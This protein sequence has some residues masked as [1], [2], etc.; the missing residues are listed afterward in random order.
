MINPRWAEVVAIRAEIG[1]AATHEA[2][3]HLGEQLGIEQSAVPGARRAVHVEAA[4]QRIQAVRRAGEA[5]PGNLQGVDDLTAAVQRRALEQRELHVEEGNVEVGI[6]DD[7][8]RGRGVGCAI[9]VEEG[10]EL[11]DHLGKRRLAGEERRAQTVHLQRFRRARR[12]PG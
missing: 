12:A 5:L 10:Q 3:I 7:Q 11:L 8:P 1:L 4:A 6:V 2:E 9:M